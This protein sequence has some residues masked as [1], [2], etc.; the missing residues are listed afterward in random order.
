M[1]QKVPIK[2]QVWSELCFVR[3][4]A[5]EYRI[6]RSIMFMTASPSIQ[7]ISTSSSWSNLTSSVG[8]ETRKR[9]GFDAHFWQGL[10]LAEMKFRIDLT[11]GFSG[12]LS[13]AFW[14]NLH[15]AW[16]DGWPKQLIKLFDSI[17]VDMALQI[18]NISTNGLLWKNIEGWRG[19]K[20]EV[21]YYPTGGGWQ[22]FR[23]R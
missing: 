8:I 20:L 9:A 6:R 7:I 13:C 21:Q 17:S 10:H 1:I 15:N 18:P 16:A 19:G 22:Y 2:F 14:S 12:I 3:N 23:L 4:F 11:W 5:I